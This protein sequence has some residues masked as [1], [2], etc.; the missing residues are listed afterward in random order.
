MIIRMLI[1]NSKNSIMKGKRYLEAINSRLDMGRLQMKQSFFK[2]KSPNK[3]PIIV[4]AIIKS[5][6]INNSISLRFCFAT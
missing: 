4:E 3:L 5:G 2:V 6:A 1:N